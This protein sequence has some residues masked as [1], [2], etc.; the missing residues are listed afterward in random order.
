[1]QSSTLRG[2]GRHYRSRVKAALPRTS[3]PGFLGIRVSFA[4]G[5]HSRAQSARNSEQLRSTETAWEC[6]NRPQQTPYTLIA[7][8]AGGRKVAGSNPVA[9]TTQTGRVRNRCAHHS[10]LRHVPAHEAD[11]ILRDPLRQADPHWALRRW[12]LWGTTDPRRWFN[13]DVG[14]RHKSVGFVIDAGRR[15]KPVITPDHP[16]QVLTILRSYNVQISES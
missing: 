14:R 9:P 15:V 12:P 16:R 6:G 2:D 1:M 7:H 13:L 8:S 4:A 10:T 5:A 3:G 11:P